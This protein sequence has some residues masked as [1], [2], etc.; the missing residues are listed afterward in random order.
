MSSVV[1]LFKSG[2]AIDLTFGVGRIDRVFDVATACV[3]DVASAA[4]ASP[5]T[6]VASAATSANAVSP[7]TCVA[8]AATACVADVASTCAASAD[9]NACACVSAAGTVPIGLADTGL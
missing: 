6:C 9:A 8:S 1:L 5:S 4:A 3:A 7:S 2:L